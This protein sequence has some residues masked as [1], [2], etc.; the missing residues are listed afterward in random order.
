MVY[1][2]KATPMST[3]VNHE[4]EF[5]Y[6]AGQLNP[7][8][9]VNPGLIYDMDGMS[10]IQFLCHE[11]YD[12]SSIAS[13]IGSK[14]KIDC[15]SLLPQLVSEDAINYPSMQLILNDNK[16]ISTGIFQRTVT[17]VGRARS[18][19]TATIRA[20]KGVNIT[21]EP[22]TLSFSHTLQK[23][24]FKVTVTVES[25]AS[26]K[27]LVSGSLIWRNCHHVVRSPIVIFNPQ[28]FGMDIE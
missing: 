14:S 21:V 16:A 8:R 5:A 17:N 4:A 9:A 6:G 19:Y 24:S 27:L 3:R 11:G 15:A 12:G 7:R 25:N 2:I 13:L 18:T 10:Y 1:M 23:R 22:M 20:P 26:R 28:E